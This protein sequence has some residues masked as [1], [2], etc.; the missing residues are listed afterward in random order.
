MFKLNL[1]NLFKIIFRRKTAELK[2]VK[3]ILQA[4]LDKKEYLKIP[5]LLQGAGFSLLDDKEHKPSIEDLVGSGVTLA[6]VNKSVHNLEIE[7]SLYTDVTGFEDRYI[8]TFVII[9]YSRGFPEGYFQGIYCDDVHKT[10][11]ETV[12]LKKLMER[13]F[14]VAQNI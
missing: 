6:V 9:D 14:I 7:L 11:K 2:T 12:E 13:M 8:I 4:I 1:E 3:N 10:G 5:E